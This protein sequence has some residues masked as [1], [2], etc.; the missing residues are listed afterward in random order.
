MDEKTWKNLQNLWQLCKY[1]H[2]KNR[3]TTFNIFYRTV[4]ILEETLQDLKNSLF[5]TLPLKMK[6]NF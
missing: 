5:L 1:K 6:L 2:F 4:F 3:C